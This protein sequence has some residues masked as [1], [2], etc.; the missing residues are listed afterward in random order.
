MAE[1]QAN[2][3]DSQIVL[4]FA[5]RYRCL[6]DDEISELLT[7]RVK[8]CNSRISS[9]PPYCIPA[10]LDHSNIEKGFKLIQLWPTVFTQF[11]LLIE[12]VSPFINTQYSSKSKVSFSIDGGGFGKIVAT[13][14]DPVAFAECLVHEMAHHKLC[15]LGVALDSGKRIVKNLPEQTFPSP[16]R[17]DCLQPMS[18]VLHAQYSFTYV[19]ALDIEIVNSSKEADIL[20]RATSSLAE[21]LPKL[22][23]GC[24]VIQDNAEVD[25]VGADF[26]EGYFAWLERVLQNGYSILDK[27]QICPNLFIH[28]LDSLQ[29][30]GKS[31]ELSKYLSA[32]PFQH[33]DSESYSVGDET[34]LYLPGL[35]KGITLNKSAKTIWDLC[36]GKHTVFEISQHLHQRLGL[37]DNESLQHE[38]LQDV[39]NT[40]IQLCKLEMLKLKKA[41]CEKSVK[42]YT[43][44]INPRNPSP[45]LSETQREQDF[46]P[47]HRGD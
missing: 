46:F 11:K 17:Y 12:S 6:N 39:V 34:L 44:C 20:H 16:I 38:L 24:K 15:A 27:F 9:F 47:L 1:P 29:K 7:N 18:A 41:T 26:L 3:Y 40:V 42:D 35:E 23:F 22:E 5:N 2:Q 8:S 43:S 45:P 10:S 21:N 13:I 4:K 30:Y 14:D 31:M 33:T 28:P 36:D 25:L 32:R 37:F 19:A